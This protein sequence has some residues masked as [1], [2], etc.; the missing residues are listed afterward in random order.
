MVGPYK[1]LERVGNSYKVDLLA[2]IKVHPIF[3]LD[4]LRK[5]ANDLLPRQHN[6][7]PQPIEVDSEVEWE[8]DDVLAVRK[9]YSKL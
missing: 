4:R 9:H 1:I 8:V 5:A 6:D 3:S 2:S 7:P